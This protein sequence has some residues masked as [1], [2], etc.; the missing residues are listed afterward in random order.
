LTLDNNSIVKSIGFN[1]SKDCPKFEKSAVQVIKLSIE[2]SIYDIKNGLM[3]SKKI[4][5]CTQPIWESIKFAC[6]NLKKI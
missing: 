1:A 2:K 5:T 6:E 3:K 4:T